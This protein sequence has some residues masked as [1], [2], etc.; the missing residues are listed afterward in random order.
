[1]SDQPQKPSL[2]SENA[3][4]RERNQQLEKQWAEECFRK[5]RARSWDCFKSAIVLFI[6]AI[7]ANNF[8]IPFGGQPPGAKTVAMV[9]GSLGAALMVA[10]VLLAPRSRP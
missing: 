10:S 4:L 8:V 5:Q 7:I 3:A 2:E 6:V 1:M 9:V